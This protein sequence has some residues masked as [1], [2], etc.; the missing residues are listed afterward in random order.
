VQEESVTQPSNAVDAHIPPRAWRTEKDGSLGLRAPLIRN[1]RVGQLN[2]STSHTHK[3]VK[4]HCEYLRRPATSVK[5]QPSL[6]VGV[7]KP[8]AGGNPG[9]G[10]RGGV[11]I[12]GRRACRLHWCVCH[13]TLAPTALH[14]VDHES[15]ERCRKSV[16]G[17][18][19]SGTPIS[20]TSI[21]PSV[22]L[23]AGCD[24]LSTEHA[25]GFLPTVSEPAELRAAQCGA[26][27]KLQAWTLLQSF[28]LK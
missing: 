19:S 17:S 10:E 1:R 9:R 3:G 4:P 21:P 18:H 20:S 6:T 14:L 23:S 28:A 5:A 24:S 26:R 7:L 16:L 27:H 8:N 12:H 2:C 15:L 13:C 22:A 25:A 11:R